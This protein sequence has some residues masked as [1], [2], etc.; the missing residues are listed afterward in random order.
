MTSHSNDSGMF[1]IDNQ[2]TTFTGGIM[3]KSLIFA[4]CFWA[5]IGN[6]D[7]KQS[8]P[9]AT[10]TRNPSGTPAHMLSTEKKT[11]KKEV[12][13]KIEVVFILDNTGSMGGLIS[14]AKDKIW[15]IATSMA[16]SD[17]APDISMGLIG[18]RDRGDRYITKITSL[19]TDLDS[20]YEEL[21][22]M[23]ADGGGDSPESVNEALNK[24]I[25]H[26]PWSTDN[27]TYR[28]AFL[29]GDCPPHMDYPN[30]I[31]YPL[32]CSLAVKKGIIFNTI[33]M[34]N[35]PSTTPIW[36]EIA[37]ITNGQY[38]KVDQ[39]ASDLAVATPYDEKIAALTDS[40]DNA[41]IY[42]GSHEEQVYQKSRMVK[43]SAM[44]STMSTELKAKRGVY[45]ATK[46]G[47]K[48]F[49]GSKELI[50]DLETGKITLDKLDNNQLPENL[51]KLT[52]VQQK[53]AVDSVDALRK[54]IKSEVTL[55]QKKRTEYIENELKSKSESE[56]E[57]AFSNK[58]YE[59]IRKQAGDKG[60]TYEKGVQ[61]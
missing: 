17:P 59:T 36:K 35:F 8:G 60:I 47:M 37:A 2:C 45:N 31:K 58:V 43:S 57:N 61:H 51:K 26:I 19:T 40:L 4:A 18:Y 33:Q 25:T 28:V 23:S 41:R 14:T 52:P 24:A 15:S 38:I 54:K 27:K 56:K 55:Y 49:A 6:C 10:L 12:P 34:G 21:M 48:N 46:S 7:E 5:V 30:D 32:T 53:A 22:Q 11:T 44:K 42:Y 16:Q 13:P 9:S 29:V 1:S 50:S 3:R 39:K 20:V